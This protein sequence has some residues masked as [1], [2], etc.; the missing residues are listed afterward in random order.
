MDDQITNQQRFIQL[1][2]KCEQQQH[3]I[4]FRSVNQIQGSDAR[5]IEVNPQNVSY[6]DLVD[7][8]FHYDILNFHQIITMSNQI[9]IGN[10]LKQAFYQQKTPKQFLLLCLKHG[11]AII[12]AKKSEAIRPQLKLKIFPLSKIMGCFNNDDIFD[13]HKILGNITCQVNASLTFN[14]L[15]STGTHQDIHHV[16]LS[17]NDVSLAFYLSLIWHNQLPKTQPFNIYPINFQDVLDKIEF[18]SYY[19]KL[20]TNWINHKKDIKTLFHLHDKILDNNIKKLIIEDIFCAILSNPNNISYH[21]KER[22]ITYFHKTSIRDCR[23]SLI[24]FVLFADKI[25][26]Y[27]NHHHIS[28]SNHLI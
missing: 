16:V 6:Q 7:L 17:E 19:Q 20:I 5:F 18:F 25:K 24:F 28:D 4:E 13:I 15:L 21:E 27:Q 1:I 14:Q 22:I 23:Y 8:G 12:E 11:K 10:Y 9:A 2:E 3:F 26:S